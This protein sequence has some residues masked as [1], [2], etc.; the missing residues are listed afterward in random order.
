ML[1][2][3]SFVFLYDYSTLQIL[4]FF[5]ENCIKHVIVPVSFSLWWPAFTLLVLPVQN[6]SGLVV[7]PLWPSRLESACIFLRVFNYS[8]VK[9]ICIHSLKNINGSTIYLWVKLKYLNAGLLGPSIRNR[10]NPSILHVV[11]LYFTWGV[12]SREKVTHLAWWSGPHIYSC[13]VC[14]V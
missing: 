9:K 2:C 8:F 12:I 7:N 1:D 6:F 4:Y 5:I 10:A 3:L 13:W 14:V 11:E